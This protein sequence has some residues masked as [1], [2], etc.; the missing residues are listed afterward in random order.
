MCRNESTGEVL[1]RYNE[2]LDLQYSK[3]DESNSFS[4]ISPIGPSINAP[5]DYQSFTS[6]NTDGLKTTT[7][8]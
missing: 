2:T 8:T 5:W 1:T 3:I 6:L 7:G 4:P